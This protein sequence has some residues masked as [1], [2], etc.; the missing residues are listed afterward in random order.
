MHQRH[1]VDGAGDVHD[2][3][4]VPGDDG[5]QLNDLD[6]MDSKAI[7]PGWLVGI[8]LVYGDA[9]TSPCDCAVDYR[10]TGGQ[11]ALDIEKAA[12]PKWINAIAVLT[13]AIIIITK[14][15]TKLIRTYSFSNELVSG[16]VAI[17]CLFFIAREGNWLELWGK[18]MRYEMKSHGV[19]CQFLTGPGCDWR[20]IEAK[21]RTLDR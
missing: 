19:S 13:L 18:R 20:Q 5:D 9:L 14:H 4:S 15:A 1:L 16:L 21:M 3:A 8:I 11:R 12:A 7:L 10:W 6:G 2:D 17:V